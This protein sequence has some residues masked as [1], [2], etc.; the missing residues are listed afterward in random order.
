MSEVRRTYIGFGDVHDDL[1]MLD[2]IPG[3]A[4][5][6][7]VIISGDL[8]IRG[9]AA[10]ARRVIE[11]VAAINPAVHAQIGNMDYAEA[12]A[13]LIE[14]GVN[15][16]RVCRELAP[17][18]GIVG[19]GHSTPTP[20]GTPSEIDEATLARWLDEAA[21]L[22]APY[23]HRIAVIHTPPLGGLT[24]RLGS[25]GHV[26]SPSTRA[27]LEKVKPEVC[28][29]G[30]IHESVALDRIGRT[31]VINPGPLSGGG[32]AVIELSGGRLSAR[33]ETAPR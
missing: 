19:V 11:A 6:D 23:A 15:L 10:G 25:G 22:I 9:G 16:H 28:L 12:E 31:T 33:L 2:R 5:A 7:G 4:E 17:G 14:R 32:Y 29:T 8:T 18:L 24:D 13:Y 30:H 20:F 3:L 21:A 1:S 26:G 27:F